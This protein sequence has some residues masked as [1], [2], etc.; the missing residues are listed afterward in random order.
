MILFILDMSSE[1]PPRG[2]YR[3]Q[4]V[5]ASVSQRGQ[6]G[7]PDR[8]SEFT[9]RAEVTL[10]AGPAGERS[11]GQ[12]VLVGNLDNSLDVLRAGGCRPVRGGE[13]EGGWGPW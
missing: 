11:D 7:R 8:V 6:R 3:H 9:D 10:E 12:P 1:M 2:W 13:G 4:S 5:Q